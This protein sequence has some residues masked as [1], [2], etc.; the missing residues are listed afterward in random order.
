MK[1]GDERVKILNT[2]RPYKL[3]EENL[4][5]TWVHEFIGHFA[6]ATVHMAVDSLVPGFI[7]L[8]CCQLYFLQHRLDNFSYQVE[9]NQKSLHSN[10]N[11]QEFELFYISKFVIHHNIIFR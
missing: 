5:L 7:I 4:F 2:W 1:E 3:K 10:K 6:I 9:N 11:K 8:T